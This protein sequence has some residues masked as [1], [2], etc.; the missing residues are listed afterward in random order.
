MNCTTGII[1]DLFTLMVAAVLI[2][3]CI[4]VKFALKASCPHKIS[5]HTIQVLL[6]GAD[7]TVMVLGEFITVE[8]LIANCS[9]YRG[10]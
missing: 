3:T 1:Q 6:N 5:D 9:K 4:A 10:E 8:S 2:D 7:A